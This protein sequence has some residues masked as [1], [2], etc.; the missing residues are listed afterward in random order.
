[1][2]ALT[3][4]PG[5]AA[6][7]LPTQPARPKDLQYVPDGY[8]V[9]DCDGETVGKVNYYQPPSSSIK[10][11]LNEFPSDLRSAS[12]PDVMVYQML[13]AGFI[14]IHTGFLS[15]DRLAMLHHIYDVVDD[16]VYL[17]VRGDDL[18]KV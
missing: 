3:A 11:E 15:K 12:M 6:H 10:P 4:V 13:G 2:I 16:H 8:T 14:G 7:E 18:Y 5:L 17:T 1:M 9:I